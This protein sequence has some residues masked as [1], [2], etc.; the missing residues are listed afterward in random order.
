MVMQQ[1]DYDKPEWNTAVSMLLNV[2]YNACMIAT[3]TLDS[4]HRLLA[5]LGERFT[6]ELATALAS[7]KADDA[8]QL[9]MDELADKNTAGTLTP[10]EQDEYDSLVSAS[11]LL[12]AL[13]SQARRQLNGHGH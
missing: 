11:A 13:K 4:F 5:P 1:H 9:H 3:R 8:L 6:P 2:S 10:E 12:S 7:L